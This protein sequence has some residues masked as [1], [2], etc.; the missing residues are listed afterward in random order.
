M[1]SSLREKSNVEPW[2]SMKED[3]ISRA[4]KVPGSNNYEVCKNTWVL[5]PWPIYWM[6][7]KVKNMPTRFGT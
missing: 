2:K 5:S 3:A 1:F 6:N 7:Q 4:S